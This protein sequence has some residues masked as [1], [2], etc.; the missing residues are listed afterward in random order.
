MSNTSHARN[1]LYL[2]NAQIHWD[3]KQRSACD[4][5][6]KIICQGARDEHR[7]AARSCHGGAVK[8]EVRTAVLPANR[9][10][11][12]LCRRSGALISPMVEA[13]DLAILAGEDALTLYQFNTRVAKH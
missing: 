12:S 9:C 8:F 6:H 3:T 13:S 1:V 11:C 2:T 4:I 5:K 10:N 7:S